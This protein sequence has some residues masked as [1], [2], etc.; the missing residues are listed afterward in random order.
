MAIT[1]SGNNTVALTGIDMFNY[2]IT[3]FNMSSE[4]AIN[5]MRAKNQDLSWF[6]A[7]SDEQK[8]FVMSKMFAEKWAEIKE[9]V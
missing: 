5:E 1:P 4:D 6:D 9:E 7:F 3:H 8:D 2:F